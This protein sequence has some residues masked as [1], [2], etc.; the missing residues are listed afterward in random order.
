MTGA[1]RRSEHDRSW[2]A[3]RSAGGTSERK[4]AIPSERLRDEGVLQRAVE[5]PGEPGNTLAPHVLGVAVEHPRQL[6][7]A[8]GE[9]GRDV[10]LRRT[11]LVTRGHLDAVVAVAPRERAAEEPEDPALAVHGVLV[12][13]R[14]GG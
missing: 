10:G 3:S 6:H 5:R 1:S 8:A 14:V 11:G 4:A 7:A 13:L 9:V 12:P 2:P